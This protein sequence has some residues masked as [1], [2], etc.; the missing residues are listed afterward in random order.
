MFPVFKWSVFRS[1]LYSPAS[2]VSREVANFKRKYPPPPLNYV[3]LLQTLTSI[4]SGLAKQNR[5]KQYLGYLCQNQKP[6]VTLSPPSCVASFMDVPFK[7]QRELTDYSYP[8][9]MRLKTT[10]YSN[11]SF[12]WLK[13][14]SAC[15]STLWKSVISPR[16]FK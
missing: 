7:V 10:N 14:L 4:I 6:L 9:F 5:L 2:K 16:N 15:F 3:C 8:D 12:K 11:P 1:S 13:K